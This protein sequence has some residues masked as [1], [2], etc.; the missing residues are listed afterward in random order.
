M[1]FTLPAFSETQNY[2]TAFHEDFLYR[3][4]V[5]EVKKKSARGNSFT[6]LGEV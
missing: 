3:V 6:R 5:E 4:F 2:S 1:T